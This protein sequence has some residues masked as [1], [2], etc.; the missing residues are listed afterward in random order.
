[1]FFVAN[2]VPLPGTSKFPDDEWAAIGRLVLRRAKLKNLAPL[3]LT[4]RF[5]RF[6]KAL[7]NVK[8]NHSRHD[9][10]LNPDKRL[11]AGLGGPFQ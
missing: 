7:R 1:M 2:S 3:P 5:Q 6:S 4:G 8:L 10:P 9:N 11:L